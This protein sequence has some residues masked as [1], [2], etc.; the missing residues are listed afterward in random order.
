MYINVNKRKYVDILHKCKQTKIR[1]Y[2]TKKV[3]KRK[4]VY[5]IHKCKQDK[6]HQYPP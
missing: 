2:P 4:Y 5:I 1:R 3:N 6:L